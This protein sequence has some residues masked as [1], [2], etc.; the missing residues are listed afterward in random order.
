MINV[1]MHTRASLKMPNPRL[2]PIFETVPRHRPTNAAPADTS[3]LMA[4]A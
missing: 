4:Q 3:N 2:V 1:C